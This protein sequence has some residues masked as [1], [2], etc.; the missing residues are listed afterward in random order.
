MRVVVIVRT[1][2]KAV[3]MELEKEVVAMIVLVTMERGGSMV[4]IDQV[5]P[6]LKPNT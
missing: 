1:V 4:E 2:I 5:T 6:T 3:S